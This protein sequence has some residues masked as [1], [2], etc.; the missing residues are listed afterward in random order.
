MAYKNKTFV[1]H[2]AGNEHICLLLE[3]TGDWRSQDLLP[4]LPEGLRGLDTGC[5]IESWD[6][7]L[8]D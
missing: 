1:Q 3:P 2:T 4:P 5:E 6:S 8:D 7:S